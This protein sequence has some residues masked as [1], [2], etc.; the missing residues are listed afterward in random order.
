MKK[1]PKQKT[2]TNRLFENLKKTSQFGRSKIS[3]KIDK[4]FLEFRTYWKKIL[5]HEL[6]SVSNNNNKI[7]AITIS[8]KILQRIEG[9]DSS[10]INNIISISKIQ[11]IKKYIHVNI[12]YLTI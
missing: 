8:S 3:L 11:T 4:L 6:L 7:R 12:K 1:R 5:C 2:V 9:K 10:L